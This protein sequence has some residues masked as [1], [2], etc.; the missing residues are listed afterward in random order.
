MTVTLGWLLAL[1]QASTV[2][3]IASHSRLLKS[4]AAWRSFSCPLRLPLPGASL[5]PPSPII[6]S[7]WL[8]ADSQP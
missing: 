1:A 5:S 7:K 4:V 8:S 2:T 6:P 3:S